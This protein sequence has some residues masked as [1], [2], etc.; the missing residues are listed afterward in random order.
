LSYPGH[1]LDV[2]DSPQTPQC[3]TPKY[4]LEF[5]QAAFVAVAGETDDPAW[6]LSFRAR[7]PKESVSDYAEFND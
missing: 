1:D 3:L 4:S 5:A 7:W 2:Q 6:L